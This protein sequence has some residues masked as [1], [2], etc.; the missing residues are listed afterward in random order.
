M[1]T[2]FI[3]GASTGLGNAT[4]KL[5]QAKGWNVIA[6]MRN[7]EKDNELQQLKN[8]TLLPLDVTDINQINKTVQAALDF[9]DVDIV[10]NNAGYGLIGP[11]EA[12][13][14]EQITKQ[15]NTNLLG[16]MRV[17]QA[18]IPYFRERKKGLFITTTSMGGLLS[19]PLSSIYHATK[20][21]L[22]GW[23]E[24]MSFELGLF[25]IGIK[26]VAPG[27]II[28]DFAGRSLE[29]VNHP[30]YDAALQKLFAL[31]N[32][33]NFSTAE[34]IAEVVY[35]AATDGKDK[36]RYVAGEDANRLYNRR[37]E[38]GTEAFRK[39]LGHMIFEQGNI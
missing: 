20:W 18:F 19:F 25:N 14:D 6:T 33:D 2:I 38:I 9:T 15:L 32:E 11:M 7:P 3:T 39:E 28:T 29:P 4:A 12:Y 31:F 21:A 1:K 36:V 8:I 22:E 34:Q 5:F 24:S 35:E 23:S 37:L 30:A 27:G 16:V 13:T 26:T 17:T 10:F